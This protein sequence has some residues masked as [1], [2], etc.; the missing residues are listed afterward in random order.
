MGRPPLRPRWAALIEPH[1][2]PEIDDR[3][4]SASD[5]MNL[6]GLGYMQVIAG[7]AWLKDNRPNLPLVS[8]KAGYRFTTDA[9][10]VRT[11]RHWR[12]AT[13]YTVLRRVYR[14]VISPYLASM[15]N[16]PLAQMVER[17][18]ERVLQDV[19]SLLVTP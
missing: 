3:D 6:T 11:H 5:L 14:G 2:P 15:S 8:S 10:R 19:E 16:R 13:A 4:V 17:Q 9:Q 18:F 1:I 7:V 12:L